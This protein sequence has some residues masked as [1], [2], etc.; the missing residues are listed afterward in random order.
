MSRYQSISSSLFE[1]KRRSLSTLLPQMSIVLVFSAARRNR[2]GD[3]YY[4][5]RQN[6]DFFCLTGITQ[7]D[8]VLVMCPGHPDYAMRE[9][10]FLAKPDE[11]S[12]LW[13]GNMLH[14]YEATDISGIQSVKFLDSFKMHV[15]ELTRLSTQLYLSFNANVRTGDDFESEKHRMQ[16]EF[17]NNLHYLSFHDLTPA[18]TQIRLVK[19][20]EELQLMARAAKITCD[21]FRN[22]LKMVKPG[23]YEY[24]VEA[25]ISSTFTAL[26]AEGHAFHPIV[27]GGSNACVLHYEK[28]AARLDNGSL[29]LLDFGAEYA[30]YAADCSRT[31]PVN[32]KF[33]PHQ[34][35]MYT[36]VLRVLNRLVQEY[37]PGNTINRLNET[38]GLLIQDELLKMK[39]ITPEAV[40]CQDI[41]NPEYKKYFM[42]GAAHF[43]GLDVHDVGDKDE[44]FRSGMVLTC[45]PGLYF[46][47]Q[48]IGIRL[49]NDI[50]VDETPVNLTADI[51]IEIEEIETLMNASQNF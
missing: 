23:I 14:R 20:K 27:A 11:K 35:K 24:E 34:R 49:E 16:R 39:I 43:L 13:Y 2:T 21:A 37:V 30:N 26:G 17:M 4:P 8:S 48:G 41:N 46:Q 42:H 9:C 47:D 38:A 36:A 51:P 1:K 33:S 29:L 6:S 5:Y 18:L 22:V 50:L 40:A 45:E 19:E 10:L 25:S 31:I 12:Q 28:N 7:P 44:V 32:G 15:D 3:Q